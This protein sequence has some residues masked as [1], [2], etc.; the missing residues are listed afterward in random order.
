MANHRSALWIADM[1]ASAAAALMMNGAKTIGA[2]ASVIDGNKWKIALNFEEI[3]MIKFAVTRL[4]TKTEKH[5]CRNI[6]GDW[7]VIDNITRKNW[8]E[9]ITYECLDTGLDAMDNESATCDD[10]DYIFQLQQVRVW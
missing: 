1:Q 10:A 8:H 3:T 5:E 6:D 7:E 9:A 4:N 2:L